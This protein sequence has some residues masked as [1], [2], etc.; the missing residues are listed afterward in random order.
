[1]K[2]YINTNK[3]SDDNIK[4]IYCHELGHILG[5][6]IHEFQ[7]KDRD[8]YLKIDYNFILSKS[9]FYISQFFMRDP[10]FYD[11]EN[12]DFDYFS[13]MMCME[14]VMIEVLMNPLPQIVYSL[15]TPSPTDFKKVRDIYF[16][17]YYL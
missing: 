11:I 16:N 7:R 6:D 15:V 9:L 1:M 8:I 3:D 5:L 13:C 2:L 12:Y 17:N 4:F 10:L 14:D